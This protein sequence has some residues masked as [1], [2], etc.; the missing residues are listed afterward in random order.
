M[1]KR[2]FLFLLIAF[3]WLPLV[4]MAI[5]FQRSP[6]VDENRSLAPR[7]NF[8]NMQLDKFASSAVNWFND[9]YGLRDFF[10][11]AKTQVDFSIFGMSS[12]I[13][14]GKDGWLFYKSVIDR[15][16]PTV[17][18][19][20]QKKSQDVLKGIS[21]LAAEL[22]K[23]NIRLVLTIGPMKNVFYGDQLQGVTKPLEIG[24]Q[25]NLLEDQLRLMDNI[26]FI[27]S[28]RILKGVMNQRAVF[29]KT[30][31]HWNDPAA[32]EVAK[33]LVNQLSA[34][35]KSLHN[36]VVMLRLS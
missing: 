4:Q 17:E 12:R 25:V 36:G 32:Y 9:H 28:V 31:F 10:I 29:H 5:G 22:K 24:R 11:R 7:P 21:F 34:V 8:S 30:D 13:Y 3:L 19:L 6:P 27:D 26:I 20:L 33:S 14:I 35:E 23:K 18:L 16:Q 2:F 1:I 15:E